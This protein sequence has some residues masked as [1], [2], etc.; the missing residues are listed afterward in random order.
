MGF[1][2]RCIHSQLLGSQDLPGAQAQFVRVPK[3]GGTLRTIDDLGVPMETAIL[4]GDILPTGFWAVRQAMEHPNIVKLNRT[5]TLTIAVIG[6]GPV[7][8]VR[9]PS[10]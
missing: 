1:T 8:Q 6:L 7:G 2:S 5:S 4:L 3:A 9:A 10:C